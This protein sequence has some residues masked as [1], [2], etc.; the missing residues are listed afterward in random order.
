MKIALLGY[1]KMGQVIE[2]IALERGHEIVLKKDEFNTYD[3]LSTADVAIDFSVPTAAVDNISN[4]FH[5]NVPVVSGTT[6]WLDRYDEMIALCN[7]KQG[8]FISSSNFSLGVNVF[9]GL[10]EYLAKIMAQF[11]SYKVSMEEIHHT[12][13]L[14]APSGTAISLA[15]GVIENSAYTNWTL[16][17][18]K[19]E[20]SSDS[21]QAKQIYIEAKRIG[22][23]PG[24]HTVTYDSIVDSIELKHTAHNREGFALGAVIAAEWLAG[25][26]GIY[27]MKDVLNLESK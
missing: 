7:E 8:G 25:K 20:D 5:A 19:E 10:N 6:G 14:D 9:F 24:T 27:T 23:V 1:G 4:C 16:E 2:R 22:D 21:K 11:D 26:K 17:S 3:G 12:Q 13:K 15:K 18:P